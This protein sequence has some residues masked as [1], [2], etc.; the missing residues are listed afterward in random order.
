[1]ALLQEHEVGIQI[2]DASG[3][4]V[5][6]YQKPE[7]AGT[8]Y[9]SAEL[10]Q[11]VQSGKSADG[12]MTVCAGIAADSGTEYACLLYF[13]VNVSRVTMYVNGERFAGGKT[14]IVPVLAALFLLVLVSGVLY[15]LLTT[16]AIKRL[17]TAIREISVRRYLP[18]QEQGVF[19]DLYDSLNTLDAEIRASDHL[20]AQTEKDAGGM[21][22]EHHPRPQN[23]AFSN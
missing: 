7:Q 10:L 9:S 1:M 5:F 20:R 12:E 16:R 17:T 23:T 3:S 14:M 19:H 13:P 4:E 6:S 15:G 8:A 18:V 21:D 2:L 22:C 11:L